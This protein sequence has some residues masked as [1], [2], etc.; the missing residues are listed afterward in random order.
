LPKCHLPIYPA[1][2]T[3]V[4]QNIHLDYPKTTPND[5]TGKAN[6]FR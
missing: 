6:L 1:E 4:E 2:V 5:G 3:V